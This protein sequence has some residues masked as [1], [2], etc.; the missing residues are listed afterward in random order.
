MGKTYSKTHRNSCIVN[1]RILDLRSKGSPR[2][3]S[4]I[5][6]LKRIVSQLDRQRLLKHLGSMDIPREFEHDNETPD[7]SS[8]AIKP[9]LAPRGTVLPVGSSRRCSD[10]PVEAENLYRTY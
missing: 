5:M 2:M 7:P 8:V 6:Q 9:R 3:V 1:N 4:P 10:V